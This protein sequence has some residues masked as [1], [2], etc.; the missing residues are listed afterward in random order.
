MPPTPPRGG[1]R[2]YPP[3][4]LHRRRRRHP[5]RPPGSELALRGPRRIRPPGGGPSPPH[6]AHSIRLRRPIGVVTAI[7]PYDHPINM[8]AWKVG[9]PHTFPARDLTDIPVA[10]LEPCSIRWLPERVAATRARPSSCHARRSEPCR[11]LR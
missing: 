6:R 3:R 10:R 1:D 7:T 8:I 4:C 11:L 5:D 2:A 9:R